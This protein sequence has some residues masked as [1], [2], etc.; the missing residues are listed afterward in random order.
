MYR[1]LFIVLGLLLV[2]VYA[3]ATFA[4]AEFRATR[5]TFTQPAMRGAH[6]GRS[7]WYYGYHGGK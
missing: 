1:A 2:G 7:F 5:R 3:Y 6:G 4:G